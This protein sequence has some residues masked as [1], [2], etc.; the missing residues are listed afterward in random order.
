MVYVS[1]NLLV[2]YVPGDR[3]RH[4]SPDVFVAKGV[5]KRERLNYLMW[6]EGKGPDVVIEL[7]SSSMRTRMWTTSSSYTRTTSACRSISCSTLT[8]TT[9]TRRCGDTG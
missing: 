9:S 6:E 4:L 2:Y 5:P 8:A 7:T 1:G 3:L